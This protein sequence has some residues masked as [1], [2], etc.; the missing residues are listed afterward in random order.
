MG[1]LDGYFCRR[2]RQKHRN[3]P[4]YKKFV[5]V[6]IYDSFLRLH[7]G[8]KFKYFNRGEDDDM[9]L[10]DIYFP[11]FSNCDEFQGDRNGILIIDNFDEF[12][13]SGPAFTRIRWVRHVS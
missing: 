4:G 10:G 7:G 11:S 1:D 9:F 12:S 5:C 13:M 3:M 2:L 6:V 8:G